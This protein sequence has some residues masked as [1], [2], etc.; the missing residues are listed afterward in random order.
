MDFPGA[1]W[2][3]VT[4]N[5]L[6]SVPTHPVYPTSSQDQVVRMCN[7]TEQVRDILW[8]DPTVWTV[9]WNSQIQPILVRVEVSAMP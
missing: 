5:K 8:I 2:V 4:N 7:A 9:S 6:N 1:I 3:Q